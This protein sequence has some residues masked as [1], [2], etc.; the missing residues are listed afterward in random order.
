MK[1][2]ILTFLTILLLSLTCYSQTTP[3]EDSLFL[4]EAWRLKNANLNFVLLDQALEDIAVYQDKSIIDAKTIK[5]LDSVSNI[6]KQM[7][8]HLR[9]ANTALTASND[10]YKKELDLSRA[11]AVEN[12][13]KATVLTWAL[14]FGLLM[15]TILYITK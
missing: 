15:T 13:K 3:T 7:I 11:V 8:V 9:T 10:S 1:R 14:S 5:N 2:N 12:K 4:I 6:Q